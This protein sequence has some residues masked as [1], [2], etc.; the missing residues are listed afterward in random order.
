MTQ[1]LELPELVY[2]N[3]MPE[4]QVRGCRIKTG[5]YTKSPAFLESL[6]QFGFNQDLLGTTPDQPEIF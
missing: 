2:Q 6:N 4:M 5:L 3:G 1:F